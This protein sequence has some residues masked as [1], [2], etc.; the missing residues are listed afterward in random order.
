MKR[1]LD[2]LTL[3]YAMTVHKAQGSEYPT[4]ITCLQDMNRNMQKRNLIYT[5]VTRA[6]ENVLFFGSRN[7]LNRAIL[8]ETTN[9]RRTLLG[10]YL[11][12]ETRRIW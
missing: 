4:V 2:E 5:A 8:T 6:K 9:Q 3:A 12:A 11:K 7:A 1:E 10:E